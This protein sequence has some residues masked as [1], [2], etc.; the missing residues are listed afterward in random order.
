MIKKTVLHNV[1]IQSTT[2]EDQHR[3]TSSQVLC[4]SLD[5]ITVS[6]DSEVDDMSCRILW[7]W[8]HLE[9]KKR[10]TMFKTEEQKEHVYIT[11]KKSS[12]NGPNLSPKTEEACSFQI[13]I[14]LIGVVRPKYSRLQSGKICY[15]LQILLQADAPHHPPIIH[16][17]TCISSDSLPVATELKRETFRIMDV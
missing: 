8:L 3:P 16:Y 14:Y 5:L 4:W 17:L 15:Y 9:D 7:Q 12:W 6:Q 13:S 10:N 2:P 1:C 11:C